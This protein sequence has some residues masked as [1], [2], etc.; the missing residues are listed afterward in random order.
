MRTLSCAP[1]IFHWIY[2]ISCLVWCRVV[3]TEVLSQR[4]SQFAKSYKLLIL[5]WAIINIILLT[6]IDNLLS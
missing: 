5:L 2:L 1:V 6:T 4:V 3:E